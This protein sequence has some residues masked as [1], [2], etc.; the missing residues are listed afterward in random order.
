MSFTKKAPTEA[1]TSN[2]NHPSNEF[3][4]NKSPSTAVQEN[5]RTTGT[6]S[7]IVVHYDIGYS[8]N[9][10]IRGTGANLSWDK[11]QPLKNV[12]N[13]EWVW[14][15]DENFTNCE[16]KVLINDYI[17]ETQENHILRKGQ[18]LEYTPIFPA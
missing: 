14:E 16:F 7:R 4:A 3:K 6:R 5:G 2:L 10:F 9:L 17:Y 15:T 11:G 1:R 8:N 12:K 13:D 18:T